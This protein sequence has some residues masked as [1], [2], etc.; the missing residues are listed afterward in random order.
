[1]HDTAEKNARW[2]FEKYVTKTDCNILEI[3][4]WT[5]VDSAFMIR[6]LKPNN[7]KYFGMDLQLGNNVD[8][9]LED[10]FKFPFEDNFFDYVVSSS[11]FEH[12]EFFWVTYLEILRVLK[13]GGLFYLNAPSTGPYHAYPVD[14]WRFYM[15]AGQSLVKW[16]IKNGYT[17]NELL[18]KFV[19]E[20]MSDVWE[21]YVCVFKK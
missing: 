2:F 17:S 12:D 15:D 16:G 9:V 4:S 13:P 14:C 20:R 18:E 8:I 3:G 21:D 5:P 11:C 10:T 19:D 1:M 6:N 7:S